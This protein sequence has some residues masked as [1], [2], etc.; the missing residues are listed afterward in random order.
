MLGPPAA[1]LIIYLA[2]VFVWLWLAGYGF[3]S[4]REFAWWLKLSDAR[5]FLFGYGV[6]LVAAW[7]F[8]SWRLRKSAT[9]GLPKKWKRSRVEMPPMK[10]NWEAECTMTVDGSYNDS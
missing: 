4:R 3:S 1:G 9:G 2:T 10:P 7:I 6:M 8:L 5:T